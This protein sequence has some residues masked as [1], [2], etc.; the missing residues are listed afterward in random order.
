MIG[1]APTAALASCLSIV[2][3]PSYLMIAS[4]NLHIMVNTRVFTLNY[5]PIEVICTCGIGSPGMAIHGYKRNATRLSTIHRHCCNAT[6]SL[7][8]DEFQQIFEV[9]TL[10]HIFCVESAWK[11]QNSTDSVEEQWL[12]RTAK[13]IR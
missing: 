3:M 1:E 6:N 11:S 7:G 9:F 13:T 10:P 8:I 4:N 5:D 2:L 12:V